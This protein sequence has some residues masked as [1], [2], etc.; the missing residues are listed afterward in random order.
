M[1]PPPSAST[2]SAVPLG[3]HGHDDDRYSDGHRDDTGVGRVQRLASRSGGGDGSRELG[4]L[5]VG[6]GAGNPE[7]DALA[8]SG[9]EGGGEG[10]EG[11]E[12]EQ[13]VVALRTAEA[14]GHTAVAKVLQGRLRFVQG[15]ALRARLLQ[16]NDGGDDGG[17]GG[18]GVEGGRSSGAS[19]SSEIS[20][21]EEISL[22]D[23]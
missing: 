15:Q 8:G 17:V 6:R 11:S 3:A 12:E 10:E 20:S 5:G 23:V 19:P 16:G 7:Q 14:S 13:L 2:P 4:G 1:L 21:E 22:Y 18:V 9:N